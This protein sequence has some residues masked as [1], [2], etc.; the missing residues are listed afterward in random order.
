MISNPKIDFFWFSNVGV[1]VRSCCTF[2]RYP[3]FLQAPQNHFVGMFWGDFASKWCAALS[4]DASLGRPE[5]QVSSFNAN[6][7]MKNIVEPNIL[8][9]SQYLK[10]QCLQQI[11]KYLTL[12]IN[13]FKSENRRHL[14]LNWWGFGPVMLFFLSVSEFSPGAKKTFRRYVLGWFC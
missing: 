2:W 6:L 12:L 1:L 11:Q 8:F 13:D 5:G 14:V 7:C 4:F 3:N 9:A 10:I